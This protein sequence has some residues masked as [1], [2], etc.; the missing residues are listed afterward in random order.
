[1]KLKI[2][3][4]TFQYLLFPNILQLRRNSVY[5]L[6][7]FLLNK[8]QRPKSN[9]KLILTAKRQKHS[10]Y[11]YST[12]LK[13]RSTLCFEKSVENILLDL[14]FHI[15]QSINHEFI[16]NEQGFRSLLILFISSYQC[17][18]YLNLNFQK[19]FPSSPFLAGGVL[20]FR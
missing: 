19:T 17:G 8:R 10:I 15:I 9:S 7:Y 1:M 6:L 4:H 5:K 11:Q 18:T 2:Q 12:F 3:S 16:E 14:T 20:L 13:D